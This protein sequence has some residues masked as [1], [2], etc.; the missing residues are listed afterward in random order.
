MAPSPRWASRWRKASQTAWPRIDRLYLPDPVYQGGK[1]SRSS[2]A[3]P[4]AR[5]SAGT[6]SP[7]FAERAVAVRLE[8][9]Q[10]PAREGVQ[11]RQRRGDLVGIVRE[12]VDDGDAAACAD[13]SRDGARRPVEAGRARAAASASGRPSARAAAS[14]ASA[15]EALW[16]PG[17]CRRTDGAAVALE[18]EA[19][20]S[21]SS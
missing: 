9:D 11:G 2:G 4:S 5:L 6:G 8:H 13:Q 15:L 17:T 20:P 10:Q 21:G 3:M 7:I 1:V 19:T 18:R 12:I 16:R 14:A